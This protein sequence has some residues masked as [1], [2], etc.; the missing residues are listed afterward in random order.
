MLDV[1]RGEQLLAS[2]LVGCAASRQ[3]SV[4]HVD[5]QDAFKLSAGPAHNEDAREGRNSFPSSCEDQC[6]DPQIP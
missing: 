6:L 3:Q 4:V 2:V 5:R 1:E